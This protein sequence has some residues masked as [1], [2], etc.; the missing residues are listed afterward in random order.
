MNSVLEICQEAADMTATMR[1]DDLFDKNVQH[2]AIFLSVMK[3]ELQS[4]MHYGDWQALIKEGCFCTVEGKSFYAFDDAVPDFYAL[5]HNTIY[6]KNSAEQVIGSLT[7][8][9]WMREKYVHCRGGD[10][11]FKIENNGVHF[12]SVPQ[13][14][15]KI[16]FVYRSNAVCVDGKT[17]EFK[18]TVTKNTDLPIFD[19]YIVK[20]GV[21]WRF[22]KRSGMDY[23]EEYNDYQKELKKRF[24]LELGARDIVL[25]DNGF[26][27]KCVNGVQIIY[28]GA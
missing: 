25:G 23:E 13:G 26:E 21:I 28:K 11:R 15:L 9:E 27:N 20:L 5:V 6:V 19:E 24:G 4:L 16:V 12:L 18:I 14:G 2:N 22:L 3:N 1:P 10:V 7:G 17:G 8:E